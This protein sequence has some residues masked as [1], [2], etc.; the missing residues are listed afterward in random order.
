MDEIGVEENTDTL[1]ACGGVPRY[2][3]FLSGRHTDNGLA[4]VVVL[5]SAV[6]EYASL[7]LFEPQAIEIVHIAHARGKAVPVVAVVLHKSDLRMHG[8]EAA[9]VVVLLNRGDMHGFRMFASAK[10]RII[11]GLCQYERAKSVIRVVVSV[12]GVV[13]RWGRRATAGL[14]GGLYDGEDGCIHNT[15]YR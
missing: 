4:I 5:R 12:I 8:L 14:S 11:F 6:V 1:G 3:H 13:G 10:V 15:A 9:S 2:F 7:G